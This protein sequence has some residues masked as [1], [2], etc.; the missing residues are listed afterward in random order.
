MTILADVY[1]ISIFTNDK[2]K[3]RIGRLIGINILVLDQQISL[4][5][6]LRAL[7][8]TAE[9][10]QHKTKKR[11]LRQYQYGCID[12]IYSLFNLLVFSF[13][14]QS[15]LKHRRQICTLVN[16]AIDLQS[17]RFVWDTSEGSQ[18]GKVLS[19]CLTAEWDQRID[20]VKRE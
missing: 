13:T 10:D 7:E 20:I 15:A 9:L 2:I 6:D 12:M 14:E 18:V 1:D 11:T 16:T 3:I 5:L 19:Q 4:C 8:S 17:L